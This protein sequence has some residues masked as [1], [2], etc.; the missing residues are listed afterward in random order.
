M[1]NNNLRR[2]VQI[3]L[4]LLTSLMVSACGQKGDLFMPTAETRVILSPQAVKQPALVADQSQ[5]RST[6]KTEKEMRSTKFKAQY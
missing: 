1:K 4:I 2:W 6:T 3:S 5:T